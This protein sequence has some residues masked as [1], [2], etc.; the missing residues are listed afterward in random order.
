VIK[1]AVPGGFNSG[2]NCHLAVHGAQT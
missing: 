1:Q 2:F